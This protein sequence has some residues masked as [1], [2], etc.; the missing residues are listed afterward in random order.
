[1]EMDEV[2][3]SLGERQT[4][5]ARSSRDICSTERSTLRAKSPYKI[6]RKEFYVECECGYKGPARDN[7]CRKCGADMLP[8]LEG[9]V[10]WDRCS[11]V[12]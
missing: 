8:S 2:S 1:M 6:I 9:P 7:A 4:I 12:T 5:T 3:D 11:Y 10:I